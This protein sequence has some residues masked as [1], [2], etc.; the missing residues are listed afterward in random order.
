MW[1]RQEFLKASQLANGGGG[2]LAERVGFEPTVPLPVRR[3]SSAVP[4][5]AWLPLRSRA[6]YQISDF[7]HF[8]SGALLLLA[9]VGIELGD[10][11][12]R[13]AEQVLH[14]H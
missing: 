12:V 4:S 1:Q 11:Y 10:R 14:R 9:G 3:I 13:V 6:S 2:P 8:R 7:Q 5:T